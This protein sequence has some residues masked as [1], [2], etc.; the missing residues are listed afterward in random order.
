M[1]NAVFEN[2]MEN[3]RTRWSIYLLN[4][5]R[6]LLKL[7]AQPSFEKFKIFHVNLIR[8]KRKKTILLDKPLYVGLSFLD[9]SKTLVYE[10]HYNY[11]KTSYPGERSQHLFID[12]DSLTCAIK[13]LNIYDNFYNVK[14]KFD[15][16]G[17]DRDSPYFDLENKKVISK[18]EDEL[19]G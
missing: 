2:A 7:A 19:N 11:I 9:L 6:K 15:F 8:V 14:H 12:T 18:M 1:N 10:F 5:R 4:T 13:R 16:S 3:L 17:Y